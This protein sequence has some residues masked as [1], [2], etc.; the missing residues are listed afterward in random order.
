MNKKLFYGIV[1][2]LVIGIVVIFSMLGVKMYTS[3]KAVKAPAL[4]P[5][6]ARPPTAKIIPATPDN[7]IITAKKIELYNDTLNSWITIHDGYDYSG[8]LAK[9]GGTGVVEKAMKKYLGNKP[10][11]NGTY[12][13]VRSTNTRMN[14]I[15]ATLS[16]GGKTY[17]TTTSTK[18][19][20]SGRAIV[21]S[22]TG[23]AQI[24]T[25]IPPFFEPTQRE[26]FKKGFDKQP[27]IEPDT[28]VVIFTLSPP[29]TI[30]KPE[31]T[32]KL[33]FKFDFTNILLFDIENK[34][35]WPVSGPRLSITIED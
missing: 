15:R 24:G 27:A 4:K 11:P 25:F 5:E 19:F 28:A 10:L 1:A 8:D 20:K 30:T 3:K 7:F 21:L 33:K 35:C 13:K 9:N 34:I 29:F 12:T 6:E 26:G 2:V 32:S 23:P 31:D 18:P 16:Y 17:Y 14:K 22:T